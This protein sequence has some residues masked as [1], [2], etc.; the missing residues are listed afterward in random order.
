M[1]D[2]G[3]VVKRG[4]TTSPAAIGIEVVVADIGQ[5]DQIAIIIQPVGAIGVEFI[6]GV[7]IGIHDLADKAEVGFGRCRR[8]A[9]GGA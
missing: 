7:A 4:L 6:V 5:R 1:V 3:V 2:R 9:T 8:A